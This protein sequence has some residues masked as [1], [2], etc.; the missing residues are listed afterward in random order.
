MRCWQCKR[1]RDMLIR[2]NTANGEQGVCGECKQTY[3]PDLPALSTV[4][5]KKYRPDPCPLCKKP[6]HVKFNSRTNQ[7]FMGC[8][9]YPLC[10]YTRNIWSKRKS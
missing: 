1:S 10:G 2:V 3:F 7:K 9:N 4:G 6:L 8:S 5:K